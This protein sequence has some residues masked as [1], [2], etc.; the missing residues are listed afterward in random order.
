MGVFWPN[1]KLFYKWI[2]INIYSI[3]KQLKKD[4]IKKKENNF[5]EV[6]SFTLNDDDILNLEVINENG[7]EAPILIQQKN[8]DTSITY[9]KTL[10]IINFKVKEIKIDGSFL[11]KN[12]NLSVFNADEID[13][14]CNNLSP[15]E[16]ASFNYCILE[17]KLSIKKFD[18][19]TK[20][21]IRDKEVK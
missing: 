21:I 10:R 17:A 3:I 6:Y 19:V 4:L 13:I 12:F 18:E 7:I 9:Q 1:Y 15:Q 5:G 8:E 11:I 2:Q 20:E 16:Y 14:L